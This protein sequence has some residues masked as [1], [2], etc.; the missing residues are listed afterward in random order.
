MEIVAVGF[1]TCAPS[2]WIMT[3]RL[4]YLWINASP[5]LIHCSS[6]QS[7]G[8]ESPYLTTSQHSFLSLDVLPSNPALAD[9]TLVSFPLVIFFIYISNVIPFPRFPSPTSPSFPCSPTHPLLLS[10]PGFPHTGAYS[11]HRTKGLSSHWCPT[12]P[13]SAAY[14]TGAMSPNMCALWLVV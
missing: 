7:R 14:A 2:S 4:N 3:L 5:R 12:R 6:P 10:G 9:W 8:G 1:S 13:F 11:L